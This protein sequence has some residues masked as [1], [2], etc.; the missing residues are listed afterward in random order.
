MLAVSQ[1]NDE[2]YSCGLL[3]WVILLELNIMIM[4]DI[5]FVICCCYYFN[6][7]LNF[8]IV[9]STQQLLISFSLLFLL[10]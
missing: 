6:I 4:I 2:P 1:D 7:T 5:A 8:I 10:L 3:S 9:I